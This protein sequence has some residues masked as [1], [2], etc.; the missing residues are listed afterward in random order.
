MSA[1]AL[2]RLLVLQSSAAARVREAVL[3]HEVFA[4]GISSG[5]SDHKL[6]CMGGKYR[7]NVMVVAEE[8]PVSSSQL[9]FRCSMAGVEHRSTLHKC[10]RGK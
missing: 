6:D 9:C 2:M 1:Q 8:I 10:S 3:R 4:E 7:G 5:R